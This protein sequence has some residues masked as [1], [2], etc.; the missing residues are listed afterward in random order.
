M[1]KHV[2]KAFMILLTASLLASC[3]GRQNPPV[4]KT[5]S[6]PSSTT[7]AESAAAPVDLTSELSDLFWRRMD[8]STATIPLTSALYSHFGGE[9]NPPIH[10]TTSNA[11]ISLINKGSDL[12]FVTHPSENEFDM[13]QRAG[14][15]LEIIPIV[16]DALVFLV[17]I[18]NPAD[19][20]ALSQLRDIYKG[21]ITNWQTVGGADVTII[22]YQRTPDSG[23]Q[24]LMLKLL[25]AGDEPM[26]PPNEWV[27]IDMGSLVETVSNFN[28]SREA[29]GYSMFY[30]VN[31]MYGN[32]RF[33]LLGI[34]GVKPS[35]DTIM[36]G[37]YPL[38]DHYY[39]VIRK[40]TP[41]DDPARK[42][43]EWLLTDDGQALAVRAG[44]IPLHPMENVWPDDAIDPVYLGD[45]EFSSGTGG[46]VLKS[47]EQLDDLIAVG[48]RRPLSDVF[49]DGFNYIE[50]INS[51]I[52]NKLQTIGSN[53]WNPP[54]TAVYSAEEKHSIRPFSGIPNDYPNY[55]LYQ[56]YGYVVIHFPEENPFFDKAT[57]F[58]IP[59]TEDISPYGL[60]FGGYR[61][62]YHYVRRLLPNIDLF[63]MR[64]EILDS[65]DITERINGHLQT[66]ADGF[67]GDNNTAK[68]LED[69]ANWYGSTPEFPYRLQPAT[70]R[71]Q[72]YLTVS[73]NLQTYDGPSTH[74]PVPYVIC[75][76]IDTGDV[77]N[78]ADFLP[79]E[80]PLAEAN[81]FKPRHSFEGRFYEDKFPGQE[82]FENYILPDGAVIH[83]AWLLGR[84]LGLH[85]TEPDG[86]KL[87]V[88]FY[89]DWN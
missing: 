39:A 89:Y 86:R 13:A 64:I 78:L 6:H 24:T 22:P 11:Y 82:A 51:E 49:F 61:T 20:I 41:A 28:N 60:G 4:P 54:S 87:Q 77:V 57:N 23:S 46:T 72:N 69:F 63:T 26:S 47:Q 19:N 3:N 8:G 36:R 2:F 29:I 81:V 84:F 76:D 21:E 52:M 5:E 80:L 17:N 35:R 55:E 67:P 79:R 45:T 88:F 18:E 73:Y 42:L 68:L 44:Y 12:I 25:M 14:V 65:P 71:W 33:K 50:Y 62:T 27:A 38:E 15:E 1:K 40:D 34:D 37:E 7:S 74:M 31:N 59:I 32:S 75:F 66:W 58:D 43:I 85:I 83:D 48:V 9:G 70:G 10:N 56:D 53:Y 16:K 30:Y